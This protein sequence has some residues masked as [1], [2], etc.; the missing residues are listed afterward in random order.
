ARIIFTS[1]AEQGPGD[2]AGVRLE[3]AVGSRLANCDFSYAEWGLHIHFVPITISGCR[4]LN[5]DGGMRFRSG[6]MLLTRSLFRGN[7]VGLRS[8]LGR[9]EISENEFVGNEIAIFVREGGE[10][11]TLHRNN[12]HDND[13]YNL[14]LGDFN[15]ADVNAPDNWWGKGDPLATIFDGRR[16]PGI[17]KVLYEPFRP[18]PIDLGLEKLFPAG[19]ENRP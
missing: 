17:G 7:R 13:R 14:R 12:F 2:W 5:N 3:R 15:Q 11:L 4:F 10:G 19:G 18:G 9:M 8:Y 16:E 6:P 1:L